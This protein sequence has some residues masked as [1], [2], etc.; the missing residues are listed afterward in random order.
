MVDEDAV[1]VGAG[2]VENDEQARNAPA[3]PGDTALPQPVP[4]P[5]MEAV[6]NPLDEAQLK[7]AAARRLFEASE[8]ADAWLDQYWD[9]VAEGWSWRQA[10]YMLWASQPQPRTPK[11]QW[12]LAT[13]VLGLTSD[14]V[15][16]EWR[17]IPGFETRVM[18]L[19]ASALLQ[20][21]PGAIQALGLA[22]GYT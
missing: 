4:F 10:V 6:L 17:Q 20:Y 8:H 13:Q 7:S 12:D 15:I 5:G 14:R 16:R 19:T 3:A 11:T 21:V 9:L 22:A 18:K 1:T 2:A